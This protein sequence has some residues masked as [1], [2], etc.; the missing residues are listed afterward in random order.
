MLKYEDKIKKQL[1][2]QRDSIVKPLPFPFDLNYFT[3]TGL[4]LTSCPQHGKTNMAKWV[5]DYLMR[6]GWI[7]KVFDPSKAWL[8]ST[9]P[10]YQSVDNK[11]T[12]QRLINPI[13]ISTVFDV[14]RIY[15]QWIPEFCSLIIQQDFELISH[16]PYLL[17]WNIAYLFE[18]CQFSMPSGSLRGTKYQE[19]LRVV[20]LGANFKLRYLAITQRPA[21]TSTKMI[22]RTG[23]KYVGCFFEDNDIGKLRKYFNWKQKEAW[24]NLSSLEKGEFYYGMRDKIEKIETPLFTKEREP[25]Y[26]EKPSFWKQLFG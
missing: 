10:T 14:A 4:F 17:P 1:N 16:L 24:E 13:S 9:I 8:N 19:V 6:C 21:D 2:I 7:V 12:W 23:Q 22:S 25:Q 3:E 18:E 11:A 20:S 5:V 26:L 15:P